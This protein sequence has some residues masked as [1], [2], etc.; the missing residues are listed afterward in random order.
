MNSNLPVSLILQMIAA[1]RSSVVAPII[2]YRTPHYFFDMSENQIVVSHLFE[3]V[4]DCKL[5]LAIP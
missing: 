2:S 5:V 1:S 4:R 3:E